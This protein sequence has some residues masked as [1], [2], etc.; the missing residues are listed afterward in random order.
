M[1]ISLDVSDSF[2][3]RLNPGTCDIQLISGHYSASQGS[4][5]PVFSW[6]PD[7]GAAA[8][9]LVFH[10]KKICFLRPEGAVWPL[11]RP[12]TWTVPCQDTLSSG[13]VLS[14]KDQGIPGPEQGSLGKKM[15]KLI[16]ENQS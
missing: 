5:F 8:T 2:F 6:D 11:G 12:C 16:H 13:L 14:F 9:T 1:G 7:Q 15:E 4:I 3:R 10:Q